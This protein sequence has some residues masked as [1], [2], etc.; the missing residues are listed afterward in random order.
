MRIQVF[1][2]G[3]VPCKLML[4]NVQQAV[5]ELELPDEVEYVTR[6]QD[7]L[8]AG[9][10]GTPT[11]KIDGEVVSVGRALDVPRIKQLFSSAGK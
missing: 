11:L 6:I 9:I 2:A 4:Q 3:C 10:T 8:D 1:G 7:L 5:R